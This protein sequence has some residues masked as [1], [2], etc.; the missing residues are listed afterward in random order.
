MPLNAEKTNKQFLWIIFQGR[1]LVVL[2]SL[3]RLWLAG[4]MSPYAVWFFLYRRFLVWLSNAPA[5]RSDR[6]RVRSFSVSSISYRTLGI[7]HIWW[8]HWA[9]TL[10][11]IQQGREEW[12]RLSKRQME[13]LIHFLPR[14]EKGLLGNK[15]SDV[16][17]LTESE[18]VPE[19]A[20]RSC[21]TH[22]DTG[23]ILAY[24]MGW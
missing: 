24:I 15:R 14:D 4:L 18:R 1:S 22:K 13:V 21:C 2:Q 12:K 19:F 16:E 9:F 17:S 23:S 20:E 11:N 3:L 8:M 6:S 7:G 5:G 10:F